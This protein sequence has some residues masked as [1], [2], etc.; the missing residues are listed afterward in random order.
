M[1]SAAYDGDAVVVVDEQEIAV[2]VRVRS[3]DVEAWR[4]LVLV[5]PDQA[6]L[7]T[8][9]QVLELR[10]PTGRR[11]LINALGSPRTHPAEPGR[12][13][14]HFRGIGHRPID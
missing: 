13:I 5:L 1:S 6:E 7:F 11:G 3:S 8:S 14:V 4:G 10:L 9:E 2:A 12:L